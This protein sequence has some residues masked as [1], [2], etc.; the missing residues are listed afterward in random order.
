MGHNPVR[1][2][3]I[4]R[5]IREHPDVQDRNEDVPEGLERLNII[6]GSSLYG[7]QEVISKVFGKE[8]KNVEWDRI[9]KLP[10][11]KID[12]ESGHIQAF[13]KENIVSA[14]VMFQNISGPVKKP[15]QKQESK[16][17]KPVAKKPVTKKSGAKK[18]VAK[19]SPVKKSPGKKKPAAKKVRRK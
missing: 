7:P 2:Y 16:S 6:I 5:L 8:I 14:I 18:S 11:G 19:K 17:K 12:I 10:E 1:W 9:Q 13:C 3:R 15:N 4:P